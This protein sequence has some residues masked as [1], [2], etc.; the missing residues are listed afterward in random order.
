MWQHVRGTTCLVP[1]FVDEGWKEL[2]FLPDLLRFWLPVNVKF[3]LL[4][5]SE[6]ATRYGVTSLTCQNSQLFHLTS[7]ILLEIINWLHFC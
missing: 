7:P 5:Q 6:Y 2:G 3:E 1:A 4:I